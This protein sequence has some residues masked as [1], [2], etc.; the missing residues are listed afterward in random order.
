M[1]SKA[2]TEIKSV[3][4]NDS[5]DVHDLTF[6]YIPVWLLER[7]VVSGLIVVGD[8]EAPVEQGPPA[9]PRH[10]QL[11]DGGVGVTLGLEGRVRDRV[12]SGKTKMI[13]HDIMCHIN[14]KKQGWVGIEYILNSS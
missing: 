10:G 14:Y 1:N 8:V 5:T 13:K 3:Q 2:T 9:G 6:N 11:V 7:G 4:M 12:A